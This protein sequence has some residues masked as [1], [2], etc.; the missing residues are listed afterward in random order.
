MAWVNQGG[1]KGLWRRHPPHALPWPTLASGMRQWRSGGLGG[2]GGCWDCEEKTAGKDKQT[3]TS[4]CCSSLDRSEEGRRQKEKR[5][6]KQV[7]GRQCRWPGRESEKKKQKRQQE[8]SKHHVEEWR[9]RGKDKRIEG[10]SGRQGR[11]ER[12]MGG[13]R[14]N[15]H[16]APPTLRRQTSPAWDRPK[17]C[18]SPHEHCQPVKI[19]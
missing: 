1:R 11:K 6:K 16:Q 19:I 9:Q 17:D 14:G 15:R 3:N 7:A 5:K 2:V 10:E 8:S 12:Q 13:C 18:I 4:Q